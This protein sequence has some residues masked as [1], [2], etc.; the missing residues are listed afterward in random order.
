MFEECFTVLHVFNSRTL[1]KYGKCSIVNH[2][3]ARYDKLF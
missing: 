3:L 2:S 1:G